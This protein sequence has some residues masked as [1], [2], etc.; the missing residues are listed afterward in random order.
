MPEKKTFTI[1]EKYK[2][3]NEITRVLISPQVYLGSINQVKIKMYIYNE[4]KKKHVLTSVNYYP[5]LMKV[6]DEI[7]VNAADN[8][9]R[10]PDTTK[11]KVWFNMETNQITVYNNGE[12]P[13]IEMHKDEKMW[14]P[15]LIFGELG[16]GSNYKQTKNGTNHQLENEIP[17]LPL[18]GVNGLGAKLANI[19]ATEFIVEIGNSKNGKYYRQI[20]TENMKRVSEPEIKDYD[21][22]SYT[23][24]SWTP[25]LARF[26]MKSLA[27]DDTIKVMRTRVYSLAGICHQKFVPTGEDHKDDQNGQNDKKSKSKLKVYIDNECIPIYSFENYVQTFPIVADEE[28]KK[29]T[30][31]KGKAKSKDKNKIKV[32]KDSDLDD[33]DANDHSNNR[34][35][36]DESKKGKSKSKVNKKNLKFYSCPN[37]EVCIT[38]TDRCNFEQISFVN[39]V[40]T[41]RGGPHVEHIVKQ[42]SNYVSKIWDKKSSATV[43]TKSKTSVSTKTKNKKVKLIT[44]E[45]IQNCLRIFVN[46]LIRDKTFDGQTKERLD[47]PMKKWDSTCE[48]PEKFLKTVAKSIS[49]SIK[50]LIQ[51]KQTKLLKKT[52]G[53]IKK[54]RITSIPKLE[55]ANLAGKV[56]G[57]VLILTEGDSALAAAKSGISAIENGR[58]YYGFFPLR[59]KMINPRG[60]KFEK[61]SNNKEINYIKTILRLEDGKHYD[62]TN[63]LRYDHIVFMADQDH[64]GSHIKGLGLNI[65]D[66]RW[67]SLLKIPGFFKIFITPIVTVNGNERWFYSIPEYEQWIQEQKSG[68]G[69]SD[70][71]LKN[72]KVKYFK[73]LGTS[74]PQ[75]CKLY[76][77]NLEE[78]LIDIS[79]KPERDADLLKTVFCPKMN[80]PRKKW[81]DEYNENDYID[82]SKTK[83][84]KVT[85]FLNKEY[86]AYSHAS[87]IRGIPKLIDGFKPCQR[88]AFYV[89]EKKKIYKSKEIKVSNLTGIITEKAE[90]HHGPDSLDEAIKKMARNYS[91]S[92]NNI[93]LLYPSGQCGTRFAKKAGDD[94]ASARYLFTYA[95]KITKFIFRPEDRNILKYKIDGNKMIE[96]EFYL[97]IIAIALINSNDGIGTGFSTNIPAHNP[98][99]IVENIVL[100]LD[101]Q[102]MKSLKPW[103]ANHTGKIKPNE[104]NDGFISKGKWHLDLSLPQSENGDDVDVD[105]HSCKTLII[106]ELPVHVSIEGYRDNVIIKKFKDNDDFITSFTEHHTDNTVDFR[107]ELSDNGRKM[108]DDMD[109][110]EL[111]DYLGLVDTISTRNMVVFDEQNKLK[112]FKSAE[113]MLEA[114]IKIRLPFYDKRREMQ[115][116]EI[117]SNVEKKENMLRFILA[118]SSEEL[119]IFNKAT[120]LPEEIIV[121]KLDD[122][123]YKKFFKLSTST[124]LSKTTNKKKKNANESDDDN[125]VD[126][127]NNVDKH[128]SKKKATKVT[129]V[130]KVTKETGYEYLLNQPFKNITSE[131]IKSLKKEIA[132][133][134]SEYERLFGISSKDIWKKELGE[135]LVEL[136]KF[137]ND[138]I[139]YW[140]AYNSVIKKSKKGGKR[141]SNKRLKE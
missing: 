116:N 50:S 80:A 126:S 51:L 24:I 112:R 121:Q 35:R 44:P 132:K 103:Y 20:F 45:S 125:D 128:K 34:G 29:Q 67:P 59:G 4:K 95:N 12:S 47:T 131:K 19:W 70:S 15:Q 53:K 119:I 8:I 139:E 68:N 76:F 21:G 3:K 120:P 90:Y 135:F 58:D 87:N 52:D 118:V 130:T 74:S 123:K 13:E 26:N 66:L 69:V 99:D 27:D 46:C 31:N 18:G 86:R 22:P 38:P 55:D 129:K 93:N 77:S 36:D 6:F 124:T 81:V 60:K 100:Y 96:P 62:N 105:A 107:L 71:I 109:Q 25:D 98:R 17:D 41:L 127:T 48:L 89:V 78:H 11:I 79:Y 23:K 137:E 2:K 88:K 122:G 57:C 5:A 49:E 91:G 30:S 28:E 43:S 73:G 75:Q 65:F 32:D 63:S 9:L 94:A 72:V 140:S 111:M 117:K 106:T 82:F 14:V 16:S 84:L 133:G 104:N 92:G 136:T 10:S 114:F 7:L 102:P 97:P 113:E 138:R 85:D 64:D 115:L 108:F 1:E 37:W 42:V 101:D 110:N 83:K 61:V 33:S 141:K 39:K 56:R 134:N 40:H 54:G